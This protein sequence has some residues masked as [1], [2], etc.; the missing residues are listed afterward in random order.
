MSLFHIVTLAASLTS[1]T[2]DEDPLKAPL[3]KSVKYV[4]NTLN[5]S[6]AKKWWL[7]AYTLIRNPDLIKLRKRSDAEIINV[8]DPDVSL[9]DLI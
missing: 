2:D 9:G 3:V 8:V 6:R 7:L 4:N 1:T 5:T